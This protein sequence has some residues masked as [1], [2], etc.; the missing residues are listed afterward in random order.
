MAVFY[1]CGYIFVAYRLRT[2]AQK[3]QPTILT[4]N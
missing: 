1:R 2:G 4:L 3:S